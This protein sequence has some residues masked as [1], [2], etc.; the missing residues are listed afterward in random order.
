M[1][2]L[3]K[4]NF[5]QKIHLV[6]SSLVVIPVSFVYGFAIDSQLDISPDTT[7]EHNFFKAVMGMY[8]GF[9]LLWIL[10]IFKKQYLKAALISNVVFMLS[11]GFGRL[12]SFVVDGLPSEAYVVGTFGELILGFYGVWVLT[13]KS[14]IFAEK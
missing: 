3:S 14:R 2:L 5:I 4:S 10:G 6:I 9:A 12:I 7:D 1:A 13:K 8:L 11:L